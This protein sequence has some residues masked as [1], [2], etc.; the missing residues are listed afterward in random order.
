MALT[1]YRFAVNGR[2]L[3][4]YVSSLLPWEAQAQQF[5]SMSERNRQRLACFV[6]E[7][8]LSVAMAD[9]SHH[10]ESERLLKEVD[11]EGPL[12]TRYVMV[13]MPCLPLKLTQV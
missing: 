10:T 8:N 9:G 2:V 3:T 6:K 5:G 1:D 7:T 11:V 4:A 13:L 12:D